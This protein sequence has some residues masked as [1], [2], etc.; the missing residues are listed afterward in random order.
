MTRWNRRELTK[1]AL[2]AGFCLG[3]ASR[4]SFAAE[5]PEVSSPSLPADADAY[6]LVDPELVPALK[7][8]P[9][10]VLSTEKL[11]ELVKIPMLPPLPAP[12]PQPGSRMIPGPPGS[13][14]VHVFVVDPNP[15]AKNRPA[16]VHTHGGGYVTPNPAM[17]P[18]IQGIAHDCECVV[19]SVNYR[20]APGT[21]FPG[22]LDD[23]Y[24]AL[25]WVYNNAAALGLD[26]HRI[27][28]GGESAG[29]GHAAALALRARDRA[30]VPLV[31]QVLI[32]PMLDDRTGSSRPVPPSMGHFIW[33]AQ[34]NRFGLT[35][36][37]GVPAGSAQVPAGAVPA[38]VENLS[39]LAPAWVG[40]GSIDLFAAEDIA[41]AQRLME[42][43]VP[44]ELVVLSGG[45]HAF[46]IIVP[47][48]QISKTF[49]SSWKS[50]LRRAF[51]LA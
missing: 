1:R 31:M 26:R 29:G 42:A 8:I 14:D 25:K 36:L 24:A 41:Y 7:G 12:M 17:F 32:Y 3:A 43:S 49:T 47:N 39:G 34:C 28:V 46:D 18:L 38:R 22:S 5:L 6:K 23:N 15:G 11:A 45:Y 4:V 37:L 2:A 21:H 35:A 10:L 27:A 51:G 20:L 50:A 30:E 16:F 19:V 33:N 9:P 13:P 48:A 44:T 40:T